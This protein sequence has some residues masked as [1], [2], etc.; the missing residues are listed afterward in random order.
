MSGDRIRP[1]G[2][3]R[4]AVAALLFGIGWAAR[5]A[6]Q[7]L[8]GE[9]RG[10]GGTGVAPSESAER[11]GQ[12]RGIGG[13][14]VI[15]TIRRFGSIVVN[16]LRVT[17]SPS[18]RVTIDDTAATSRDLRLGHVVEVL[19][20]GGIGRLETAEIAV[21]S[22]VVGPVD[23]IDQDGFT[24]LGQRVV[25]EHDGR[26]TNRR[27]GEVVAVSGLRRPDGS[28]V[29]SLVEPRP[30]A[31]S[32]LRGPLRSGENG[33]LTVGTL[34]IAGL[35][36]KLAGRRVSLAGTRREELFHPSIIVVEPEV[37]FATAADRLSL[38][39]Y[40]A[41]ASDGLSLGS[42][43]VLGGVESASVAPSGEPVRAVVT[44]MRDPEGRWQVQSVRVEHEPPNV[45]N[46]HPRQEKARKGEPDRTGSKGR[47]GTSSGRGAG[48]S[49]DGSSGRGGGSRGSPSR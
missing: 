2:F 15:G 35:D 12:D 10:I 24:V 11:L 21:R 39:T 22:E 27:I 14:G 4:R 41:A 43:L 9:D 38:E 17:F 29:A 33:V 28:V 23:A 49:H 19:A 5:A 25:L 6:A 13:T 45:E 47:T 36:P 3:T 20:H 30:G 34:Q 46:Y 18:V 31:V 40:V 26:A 1:P 32:R 37:P 16:D 8:P 42:G 48:S 7:G 44:A